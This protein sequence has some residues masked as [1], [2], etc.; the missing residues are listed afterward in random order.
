MPIAAIADFTSSYDEYFMV[1]RATTAA[2]LKEA[3]R[4]RYQVYCIEHAFE[5]PTQ[6]VGERE[7]DKEDDRAVH[8][9]LVH[10]RTG[11]AAGTVRVIL[12]HP[13]GLRPLPVERLLDA[14]GRRQF[15]AFPAS[16]TAEV[17]RFA[18]SKQFRRR[19][20]EEHYADVGFAESALAGA[21]ERRLMPYITLG[22]LRGIFRICLEGRISHVAAVMEPPLIRILRRLGLEF[23]PLGGLVN[24]HGLRQPCI[25]RLSDLIEHS[26]DSASLV[27]QYAAAELPAEFGIAVAGASTEDNT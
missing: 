10:R 9:L 12:P 17:S 5:D 4:L 1:V 13:G 21:G 18:V 6:Q 15:R 26:R 19:R 22:L 7:T 24:H 16:Q 25:A 27:W 20:G 23:E 11:E 2:H 3:H 14:G 8:T